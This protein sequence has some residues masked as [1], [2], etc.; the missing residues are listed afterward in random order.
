[1]CTHTQAAAGDRRTALGKSPKARTQPRTWQWWLVFCSLGDRFIGAKIFAGATRED[2]MKKLFYDACMWWWKSSSRTT[3]KV[4]SHTT[5]HHSTATHEDGKEEVEK[6]LVSYCKEI[7]GFE[8][9]C[10]YNLGSRHET[11]IHWRATTAEE[12]RRRTEKRHQ[13]KRSRSASHDFVGKRKFSFF[14]SFFRFVV[15]F[16]LCSQFNL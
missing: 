9:R 10:F 5:H 7:V 8:S 11:P 4:P 16:S 3:H 15:F 1:M 6:P 12:L 14:L 2:E 13:H